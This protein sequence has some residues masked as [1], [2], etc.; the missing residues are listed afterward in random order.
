MLPRECDNDDCDYET[1]VDSNGRPFARWVHHHTCDGPVEFELP[2][3]VRP[4]SF[5][6]YLVERSPAVRRMLTKD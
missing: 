5:L 3:E 1:G 6:E 2:T 4:G